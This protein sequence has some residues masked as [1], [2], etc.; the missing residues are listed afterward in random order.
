[1]YFRNLVLSAFI[2]AIFAGLIFSAYQAFFITPII[3]SSEVYEVL[4]PASHQIEAWSPEDGIERHTWSFATNFLL[5]FAYALILL[6]AMTVKTNI[7]VI[8]GLYWGIAA[9]LTIFVAPA[10]GLPPEIPGMEAAFLEGRQ[11]WWIVTLIFTAVSLWMIAFQG[12]F[13][14]GIG[15]VLI[16]IPHIFGAPQ[17]ES[18]GFANTDP[19]AVEALTTL[20]HQ[21]IIQTSIANALLWLVI[22]ASAGFLVNKFISPFDDSDDQ[23]V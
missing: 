1:M 18:H 8:K 6:S 2:I 14:K 3:L 16:T 10:L 7:T 9:Y 5:C 11:V 21:F 15:V 20:W 23:R 17:S 12:L 22:G 19:Q 13:Y 4:E